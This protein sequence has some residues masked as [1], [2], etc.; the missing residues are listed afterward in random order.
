MLTRTRF[1][2]LDFIND[3]NFEAT[4]A[5]MLNFKNEFPTTKNLMPLLFTPNVDDVVAFNHSYG[6]G[7][8]IDA[9]GAIVPIRTIQHIAQNPNFGGEIMII[10]LGCEKLRPE[11]LLPTGQ[12]PSDS[13]IL[14]LQDEACVTFSSLLL[15]SFRWHFLVV[16]KRFYP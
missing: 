3:V 4:I 2:D 12:I 13:S 16:H 6:C 7:I 8:A 9:P 14:Y 15:S 5:S 1:F 10:G 11:R